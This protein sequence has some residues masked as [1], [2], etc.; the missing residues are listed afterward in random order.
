MTHV[1]RLAAVAL[2]V[3]ALAGCGSTSENSGADTV[4]TATNPPSTTTSSGPSPSS[5]REAPSSA[6]PPG[7][8]RC[9]AATLSGSIKQEDAGA[10]NRYAT[11]MV[12]NTGTGP[13]TLYGYG[14]L[15]L[16]G[17]TGQ[18]NPTNLLRVPT[19]GP[20]LVTLKPGESAGKK[21]H[22]GVVPAGDEPVTGPCEPASSD[23]EVIP[24]DETQPF[25]VSFDFG[26]VCDKG[27]IEG[28]AYFR[29]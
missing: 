22:W 28:S 24:P 12:K 17:E 8:P 1:V 25:G 20:G 13:C 29:A 9:S 14:G 15:Q 16:V 5:S 21:L 7:V 11:L 2:A 6:T 3:F 23:A 19:P 27:R 4:S 10:G 18:A 26:S